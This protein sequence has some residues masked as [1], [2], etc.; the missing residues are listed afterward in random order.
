MRTKL[1][2]ISKASNPTPGQTDDFL[3]KT[4][5]RRTANGIRRLGPDRQI[6]DSAFLPRDTSTPEKIK[7]TDRN[8]TLIMS[9]IRKK[10]RFTTDGISTQLNPAC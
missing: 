6:P 10:V 9:P 8:Y 3:Q 5:Q 1:E 4:R 2:V 7:V